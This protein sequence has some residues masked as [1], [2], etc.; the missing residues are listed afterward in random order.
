MKAL[1]TVGCLLVM[2]ALAQANDVPGCKL[3]TDE[4]GVRVWQC[5]PTPASDTTAPATNTK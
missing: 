5:A 3:L 2:G 1:V 4:I